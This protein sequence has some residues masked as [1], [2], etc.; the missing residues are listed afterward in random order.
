MLVATDNKVVDMSPVA[1]LAHLVHVDLSSNAITSL[2]TIYTPKAHAL[3]HLS[4]HHNPLT[5]LAR[6]VCT[7]RCVVVFDVFTVGTIFQSTGIR[8]FVLRNY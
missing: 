8:C 1:T 3:L 5:S 2:P 7:V 4:L 6:I